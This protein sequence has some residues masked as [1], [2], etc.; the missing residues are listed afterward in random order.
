MRD[1][2]VLTR[3]YDVESVRWFDMFPRTARCETLVTLR[4]RMPAGR[5]GE[6]L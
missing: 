5:R 6:A 2:R 4:R 3:N 1:L